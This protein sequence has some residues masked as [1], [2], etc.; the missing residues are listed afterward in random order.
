MTDPKV[1]LAGIGRIHHRRLDPAPMIK[2]IQE[3]LIKVNFDPSK[4]SAQ[5]VRMLPK[6]RAHASQMVLNPSPVIRETDIEVTNYRAFFPPPP[7]P[8]PPL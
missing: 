1:A 2:V 5:L 3:D 4:A 8:P 7:P 6:A